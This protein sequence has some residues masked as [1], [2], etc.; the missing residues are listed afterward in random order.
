MGGREAESGGQKRCEDC[1]EVADNLGREMVGAH[2][3][4]EQ[5]FTSFDLKRHGME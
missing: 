3:M 2:R 1:E 4:L 5:S